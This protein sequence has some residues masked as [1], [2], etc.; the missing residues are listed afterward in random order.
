MRKFFGNVH[1][2]DN[3][4]L[5]FYSNVL[6]SHV[7]PRFDHMPSH[8]K[9]P[10]LPTVLL[11]TTEKIVMIKI[12]FKVLQFGSIQT[13]LAPMYCYEVNAW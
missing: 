6:F 1:F 11:I 5:S 2:T 9:Q 4:G 13:Q 3:Y 10:M 7:L 12:T 8:I